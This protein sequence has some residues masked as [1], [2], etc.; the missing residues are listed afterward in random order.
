MDQPHQWIFVDTNCF[1]HLRDLKDLPWGALFSD[2][3][4]I[5]IVVAPIVIEELDRFKDDRNGRRRDRARSA[6]NLIE[7]ASTQSGFRLLLKETPI[8]ISLRIANQPRVDW[9]NLPLLDSARSDD[10][11]VASVIIGST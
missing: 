7:A 3:R 6:L 8:K 10:Q 1:I 11:L 4:W 9:G 2:A 5:D